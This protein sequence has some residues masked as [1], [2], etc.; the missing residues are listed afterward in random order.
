MRVTIVPSALLSAFV[1]SG[2]S[3]GMMDAM[4][5][6]NYE[7][8]L[9]LEKRLLSRSGDVREKAL[10]DLSAL[11]DEE[12]K[13]VISGLLSCLGGDPRDSE[14]QWKVNRT[15]EAIEQVKPVADELFI[16]YVTNELKDTR[17]VEIDERVVWALGKLH[18]PEAVSTPVYLD[19]LKR[20]ATVQNNRS[21]ALCKS[22]IGKT[23]REMK[24][25]APAAASILI[26][27]ASGADALPA[28]RFRADAVTVMNE[29]PEFWYR[30]A[31]QADDAPAQLALGRLYLNGRDAAKYSEGVMWLRKALSNGAGESR[32]DLE[33][34]YLAETG[35][36]GNDTEYMEWLRQS[37]GGGNREMQHR[38]G[39]MLLEGKDAPR[40]KEQAV[41]WLHKAADA[42]HADAQYQIGLAFENGVGVTSDLEIAKRWYGISAEAGHPAARERRAAIELSELEQ[43]AR[44]GD[45][46]SQIALGD[47]Y[48]LRR[49]KQPTAALEWYLEAAKKGD[50]SA[51]CRVGRTYLRE[52]GVSTDEAEAL[53]W[54]ERASKGGDEEAKRLLADIKEQKIRERARIAREKVERD[55]NEKAG[56]GRLTDDEV[57]VVGKFTEDTGR[58]HKTGVKVAQMMGPQLFSLRGHPD[59]IR[60]RLVE[61]MYQ[62]YA[63][64]YEYEGESDAF[65]TGWKTG[66]CAEAG[67]ADLSEK[68]RT[69][70]FK[71][72]EKLAKK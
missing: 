33:S 43:K 45:M 22:I 38:L 60:E 56:K 18:V 39:M 5:N 14:V 8:L 27:L 49:P 51:M 57:R 44:R 9:S 64:M 66:F 23:F 21:E 67:W 65:K 69:E 46:A 68:Y 17:N 42:G 2:C 41:Q 72:L 3:G 48:L 10:D 71:I 19:V 20:N 53:K 61:N 63:R 7:N 47:H 58:G 12:K 31:A 37:A 24:E 50:A 62:Q 55:R 6:A 26:G 40:N 11:K 15:I 13:A 35:V 4:L 16:S 29:R 30:S 25:P 52:T 1:F 34:A 70:S 36:S 28:G 32:K 59:A 54:L